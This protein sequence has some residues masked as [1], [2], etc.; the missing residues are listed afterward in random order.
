M[1][2]QPPGMTPGG[3]TDPT[4]GGGLLSTLSTAFA[5][6]LMKKKKKGQTATDVSQDLTQAAMNPQKTP[7]GIR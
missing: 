7:G 3:P 2:M 5:Q 1:P 4:K 6:G